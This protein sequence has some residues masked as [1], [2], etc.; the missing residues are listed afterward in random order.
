MTKTISILILCS[1]FLGLTPASPGAPPTQAAAEE[2]SWSMAGANPQRTSWVSEEVNPGQSDDFGVVWYRPIEAYIPQNVQIITA[3][4][5]LYLSTARGLYALDANTGETVWR[6]DTQMPMG[7]SPTVV[8][9]TVYVG[10]FDRKIHALNADS[11]ALRWSFSGA[12]AGFSVNPL[13]VEGKV[14]AGNRDGR[15]YA[16]DAGNGALKW[17]Y[18]P[19]NKAA[20]GPILTSA[21]YSNGIIYFASNDNHAYAL[22][23][24]NGNLVWRSNIM[25]GDA[26]QA[27]WP[28]VLDDLVFF[29]GA[30]DYRME[31]PGQE[32]IADAVPS[33]S[34]YQP[35]EYNSYTN[36]IQRDDVFYSGASSGDLLGNTFAAGSGGD[37]AGINWDWR[38]GVTVIDGRRVTEYYEDDGQVR[39]DRP[40]NKPWRR[41]L[42]V[43]NRGDGSEF[44]FDSDQDGNPEYAPYL[45]TGTYSGNR[46]PPVLMPDKNGSPNK[47]PYLFNLYRNDAGW[48]I[49]RGRLMGWQVGTR[50]MNEAGFGN[51]VD[52]PLAF[53]GGGS[54]VYANLCCDRVASWGE[55]N[56][57]GGGTFWDYHRTLESLDK[58]N[59]PQYWQRSLAPT[60]DEMWWESSMWGGLPRLLGGY[61]DRNSI[62]HSHGLQNPLVPFDGKLFTHRSNAIIALGANPPAMQ[63]DP[64]SERKAYEAELVQKLKRNLLTIAPSPAQTSRPISAGELQQKLD[65]EISAMLEAGQLRPGY[66]VVG[67]HNNSY[68]LNYFENPGE[69]LLT[70]SLAY[71][72]VSS[73]LQPGL[74]DY[75]QETFRRY[76]QSTMVARMGWTQE[77]DFGPLAAREAMPLPP[78]VAADLKNHSY[79]VNSGGGFG[80]SY[81]QHNFYALWKY[82]EIFPDQAGQAYSQ[83]KAK[84]DLSPPDDNR[85]AERPWEHNG[86]IAGYFGF[87]G[88]QDLAGKSSQDSNLRNQVQSELDRLLSLR[89]SNFVKDRPG[90]V[91]ENQNLS[92][93][94][95]FTYLV[96][97]LG[98]Y[99]RDHIP[100][101]VSD[102]VTSYDRVAPYWFVS[103]YEASVYEGAMR[104]LYDYVALFQARALI[105]DQS[106]EELLPY[107]DVPAFPRG[108][109]YYLQNLV[110]LMEDGPPPP[111]TIFGDVL[112]NH[113]YFNE[114]ETLYKAGY[115]AGCSTSPLLYCP[116]QAMNRAE[117]AVF[118]ERGIH[119][120][121]VLPGDPATAQFSDLPLDSWAAKWADA[122][123]SDG[124][125]AGCGTNPLVYCPWQG[126]TRAEGAVFYLRMLN[127]ADYVPSNPDGIFADLDLDDWKTKW[128]EAAF[129]ADLIPACNAEPLRFCP[130]DA[131]TRGLAAYMM[132]QAKN[133]E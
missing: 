117:S 39:V 63:H 122:L 48:A 62:Y 35:S 74:R 128:A 75:L 43:L 90:D 127:G 36:H 41:T 51:A 65:S 70:L 46:Y 58:N 16:L 94:R 76:F 80:W 59:D 109:L 126:H 88:L 66:Y 47:I 119:G 17:Q 130:D 12:Q 79:S 20:V 105:L 15:F 91:D 95:N 102:A 22:N 81:P 83:A 27:W 9:D 112:P 120:T 31:D 3:R 24:A 11:G 33:G 82:A 56:G 21:A 103:R 132:V 116:D 10:G 121:D 37:S 49:P 54:V 61:G 115:T 30:V 100:G 69:T 89:A 97:E 85:L 98:D 84:L 96:P 67:Q 55:L 40:S 86:Y 71:P 72:H 93:M 25:P 107:L 106:R 87:L 60:Y 118:V 50:Y 45:Y 133:L 28:V 8:G 29:S 1:L 26:Y 111:D 2:A 73:G 57:D 114:I 4:S 113:P 42:V 7:H 38:N 101:K 92:L 34:S 53:S 18:P 110:T 77:G 52:E 78:E 13:V 6:F 19:A 131:L 23:A 64:T 108:D 104:H 5:K 32:S 44:T 124:F 99:L 68:L 129:Q 14:F 125:T 123:Y